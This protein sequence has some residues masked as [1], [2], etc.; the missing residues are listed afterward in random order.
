VRA[1]LD[2]RR[3]AGSGG[4][5]RYS[6]NIVRGLLSAGAWG[7]AVLFSDAALDDITRN[8]DVPFRQVS[9]TA[10][11]RMLHRGGLSLL[12]RMRSRRLS[13]MHFLGGDCWYSKGAP[14]IV[15]CHGCGFLYYPQWSFRDDAGLEA[16]R[17]H[18]H[19]VA[20]VADVVIAVSETS[21]DE[22]VRDA[23]IPL[24]KTRVIYHG[25]EDFF[26]PR[27][28]DEVERA[29]VRLDIRPPYVLYVGSINKV[30]NL[31]ALLEAVAILRKRGERVSLV[32]AGRVP[33]GEPW[34]DP[35]ID[36]L[37]TSLGIEDAVVKLGVIE[38]PD[39]LACLY[40]GAAVFAFPS[41]W[42]S[43]GLPPLEAMKCGAPVVASTAAC[44]PEITGG[45]ALSAAPGDCDGLAEAIGRL[46][47]P[48]KERN[49]MIQRGLSR[50]AEFTWD[51]AAA[52]TL[53]V[54]EDLA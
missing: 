25:V 53:A 23:G 17:E 52:E 30:K 5:E 6:R 26:R 27:P 24:E 14:T 13:L 45:A 40:S 22:L 35:G 32:L 43:F 8:A 4:V 44:L 50:A 42:E 48:G 29:L 2:C 37:A 21:R 9:P 7:E 49:E 51:K 20:R 15:T 41:H 12:Q 1:G 28:A 3:V 19:R 38:S 39:T 54:Y 18:L 10:G 36:E 47:Q 31:P 34:R 16:A 11:L 33:P 46:A